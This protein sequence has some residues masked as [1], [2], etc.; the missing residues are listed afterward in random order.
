MHPQSSHKL[1]GFPQIETSEPTGVGLK[2]RLASHEII[3]LGTSAHSFM[4]HR[5]RTHS[6][7]YKWNYVFRW[8]RMWVT[9]HHCVC[10]NMG[11]NTSYSLHNLPSSL[12][13]EVVGRE[14]DYHTLLA[15]IPAFSLFYHIGSIH[16]LRPGSV[17]IVCLDCFSPWATN[18]PISPIFDDI[19]AHK[20]GEC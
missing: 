7:T 10:I 9:K 4:E 1:L 6:H 20:L 11:Q 2:C 16:L 14:T 13:C 12:P 18:T 19:S 8:G 15:H 5:H 3:I 17:V